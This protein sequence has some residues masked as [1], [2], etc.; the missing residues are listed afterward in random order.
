MNPSPPQDER[1]ARWL[2]SVLV[3][4]GVAAIAYADFRVETHISLGYLYFLPLALSAFLFPLRITLL[5]AVACTLLQDWFGPFG[6][7]FWPHVLRNVV[8]LLGYS[9]V[10]FTINRLVRQ[11]LEYF[12][13]IR[14]QRDELAQE[15]RMAGELQQRLLPPEAPR[16][17]GYDIAGRMI[18]VSLV[19]GDFYDYLHL[20]QDELGFVIADVAGKGAP[21]A[22][23]M[24]TVQLALRMASRA[25]SAADEVM[26]ALNRIMHEATDEARFVTLFYG[27]LNPAGRALEYSN[28]GHHPP[29]LFRPP[30]GEALWLEAGGPVLGLLPEADYQTATVN[31]H[32]GDTL[33]LYTDGLVE[34]WNERDE[35]YS[36]RRLLDLVSAHHSS[37]AQSLVDAICQSVTDFRGSG[38]VRDDMTVI[39]V[40]VLQNDGP[41][42]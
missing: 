37:S 12:R 7:R 26:R 17:P 34:S 36:R 13:T 41:H 42:T 31:L 4:G 10:G 15:L 30:S 22:L 8:I 25:S 11:R 9:M 35:D 1:S 5:L 3:L 23:L 40:R 32:A 16:C 29:L 20:Q 14:H 21:A 38:K 24:P 19:G 33:I 27:R 18:P 39:A 28:A 6:H 2:L